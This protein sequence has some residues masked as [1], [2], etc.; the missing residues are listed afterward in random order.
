M[1]GPARAERVVFH[2]W[3]DA[4]GNRVGTFGESG[5]GSDDVFIVGS[6]DRFLANGFVGV[7]EEGRDLGCLLASEGHDGGASDGNGFVR[8]ERSELGSFSRFGQDHNATVANDDV[9]VGIAF[10]EGDGGLD[11][12]AFFRIGERNGSE[13]ADAGG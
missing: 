10:E 1:K 9:F 2:F 12:L 4:L 3:S 13:S 5:V 7:V 8:F 6:A 11:G